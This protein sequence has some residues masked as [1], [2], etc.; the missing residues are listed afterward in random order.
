M[1]MPNERTRAL[2]WASSFLIEIA[3]DESLPLELRRRAVVIARHFPTIA[4]VENMATP[5]YTAL[6]G[7]PLASP[8]EVDWRDEGRPGPLT[9]FTRLAWPEAEH[10]PRPRKRKTSMAAKKPSTDRD[11]G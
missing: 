4:D 8:S 6:F 7:S 10:P 2:L 1:T 9:Y 5:Q 3:R 11:L